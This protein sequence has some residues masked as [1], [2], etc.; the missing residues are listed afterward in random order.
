MNTGFVYLS[1]VDPSIKQDIRYAGE[2]NFMGCVADG[3]EKP[4]AILTVQAANALAEAQKHFNA[5]G[6]SILVLDAYRPHSA[7]EHFWRWACDVD[8]MKMKEIYYPTYDDKT[9]LFEDGFIAKYSKHSRGSTV[10]ITLL[11]EKG[12][13]VD[14]GGIFDFFGPVSVTACEDISDEAKANRAV[15]KHG[16]E[17]AGFVNYRMEW[18]HYEL[19]NEPFT[20]KPEHH[21]DFSV[22]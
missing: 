13:E 20:L 2:N 4:V 15:L 11:D 7:V 12:D 22:S 1:E 16:M 9:K 10:D 17:E 21:F 8:D 6:Y 18:W 3:Y 19:E 5:L 14:M